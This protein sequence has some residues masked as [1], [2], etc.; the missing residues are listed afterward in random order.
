MSSGSVASV[1][2]TVEFVD[3]DWRYGFHGFGIVVI[4]EIIFFGILFS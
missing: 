1:E 4:L 2:A 3:V